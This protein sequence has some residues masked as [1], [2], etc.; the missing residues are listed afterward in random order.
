MKKVTILFYLATI[1]LTNLS[2][3]EKSWSDVYDFEYT[4]LGKSDSTLLNAFGSRTV[5]NKNGDGIYH[6]M[7]VKGEPKENFIIGKVFDYDFTETTYS[8]FDTDSSIVQIETGF[9][10]VCNF[11]NGIKDTASVKQL[12]FNSKDSGYSIKVEFVSFSNGTSY[13]SWGGREPYQTTKDETDL[14][15]PVMLKIKRIS[16]SPDI[17]DDLDNPDR[18]INYAEW[19]DKGFYRYSVTGEKDSIIFNSKPNYNKLGKTFNLVSYGNKNDE[20]R[21]IYSNF[22]LSI[23][24][25]YYVSTMDNVPFPFDGKTTAQIDGSSYIWKKMNI[26]LEFTKIFMKLELIGEN[27]MPASE[28]EL[29]QKKFKLLLAFYDDSIL[30]NKT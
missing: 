23:E 9:K 15:L 10:W 19:T 26:N 1:L 27:L 18:I 29:L 2:A 25:H 30:R 14:S 13:M 20:K 22:Y 11:I 24:P 6:S 5:Y 21:I 16:T 17:K 7:Y 12:Y 3:Q 4:I 28:Y 8:L